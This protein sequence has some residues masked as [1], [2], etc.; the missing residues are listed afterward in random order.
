MR[1]KILKK[2]TAYASILQGTPDFAHLHVNSLELRVVLYNSKA[3]LT[4][5][6]WLLEATEG[7]FDRIHIVV[8]DVD[9]TCLNF[10]RKTMSS[11]YVSNRS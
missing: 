9:V 8:V 2:N 3:T 5:N 6:T 4:S 7:K 10:C 11:L 1:D